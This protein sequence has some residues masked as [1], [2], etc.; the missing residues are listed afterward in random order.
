MP[1]QAFEQPADDTRPYG[2]HR[3]D[4]FAPKLRRS[5][6]LFGRAALDAWTAIQARQV[7]CKSQACSR[8]AP[9][10]PSLVNARHHG[11]KSK[12]SRKR[13]ISSSPSGRTLPCHRPL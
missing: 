1:A 8:M 3:Y 12:R 7:L 9:V 2:S 5:I 13:F 4:V 11:P 10:T 6:T